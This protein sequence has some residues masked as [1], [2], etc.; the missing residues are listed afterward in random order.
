MQKAEFVT[1]TVTKHTRL[2]RSDRGPT[3]LAGQ[4]VAPP[5]DSR[6][7]SQARNRLPDDKLA[8]LSSREYNIIGFRFYYTYLIPGQRP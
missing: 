6:A 8:L 4:G 5:L 3:V 1:I 2:Y 7:G